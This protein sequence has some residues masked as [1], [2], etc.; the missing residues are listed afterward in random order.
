MGRG[1]LTTRQRLSES[2]EL[3]YCPHSCCAHDHV[4]NKYDNASTVICAACC[5]NQHGCCSVCTTA[6]VCVQV[7]SSRTLRLMMPF[8][9]FISQELLQNEMSMFRSPACLS[10]TPRLDPD[11]SASSGSQNHSHQFA[12]AYKKPPS[13]AKQARAVKGTKRSRSSP[14]KAK[15]SGM[16]GVQQ[17][18]PASARGAAAASKAGM[19]R[20][21]SRTPQLSSTHAS[22]SRR[23]SSGEAWQR[24]TSHHIEALGP[25]PLHFDPAHACEGLVSELKTKL[26]PSP[27]L[28]AR[29]RSM[30]LKL[31]R[32]C[33]ESFSI[34]GWEHDDDGHKAEDVE[35]QRSVE[36]GYSVI[37]NEKDNF[38]A[39]KANLKSLMHRELATKP[40]TSTA[41]TPPRLPVPNFQK[42][43]WPRASTCSTSH[44]SDTCVMGTET[45]PQAATEHSRPPAPE[46][47]QPLKPLQDNAQRSASHGEAAELRSQVRSL[48]SELERLR[49]REEAS[50]ARGHKSGTKSTAAD[51]AVQTSGGARQSD[52]VLRQE[53]DALR[54]ELKLS[55]TRAA[56]HETA[57]AGL[58]DLSTATAALRGIT[59][60]ALRVVNWAPSAKRAASKIAKRVAADRAAPAKALVASHDTGSLVKSGES[61][62]SAAEAEGPARTV[63]QARAAE[64]R[65]RELVVVLLEQ[66]EALRL[67]PGYAE[68]AVARITAGVCHGD[69]RLPA[70]LR[71]ELE[72]L[73]QE[74]EALR[75][76]LE[77]ERMSRRDAV[78]ALADLS[79]GGPGSDAAPV[80]GLLDALHA[81][82]ASAT[83]A[84]RENAE[85]RRNAC[86]YS[87]VGT[88]GSQGARTRT[89]SPAPTWGDDVGRERSGQMEPAELR[90]EAA[91]AAR[92]RAEIVC[93]EREVANLTREVEKGVEARREA[94]RLER[95]VGDLRWEVEK[96]LEGVREVERLRAE[97]AAERERADAA[98]GLEREVRE[99]RAEAGEAAA[100]HRKSQQLEEELEAAEAARD[101]A[102]VAL[103]RQERR[104]LEAEEQLQER[105]K[106]A[107]AAQKAQAAAEE[108]LQEAQSELRQLRQRVATLEAEGGP[109]ALREA[110]LAAEAV[111]RELQTAT[112]QRDKAARAARA[113]EDAAAA[114]AD[115]AADALRRAEEEAAAAQ[116]EAEEEAAARQTL[117]Q[118]VQDAERTAREARDEAARARA[119]TAVAER[120]VRNAAEAAHASSRTPPR[121]GAGAVQAAAME[122]WRADERLSRA[123]EDVER[124]R[125]TAESHTG[126]GGREGVGLDEETREAMARLERRVSALEQERR[127]A[128]ARLEA[129]RVSEH[130]QCGDG[131]E[132]DSAGLLR[133]DEDS[134]TV[135][136]E[137]SRM[138]EGAVWEGGR[139]VEAL[140]AAMEDEVAA[141]SGRKLPQDP[142]TRRWLRHVAVAVQRRMLAAGA[143]ARDARAAT[144]AARARAHALSARLRAAGLQSD[145]VEASSQHRAQGSGAADGKDGGGAE[146]RAEAVAAWAEVARLQAALRDAEERLEVQA[147]ELHRLRVLAGTELAAV[148]RHHAQHGPSG[149]PGTDIST[150]AARQ[151]A[152]AGTQAPATWDPASPGAVGLWSP[153]SV[154]D[155]A[156]AMRGD[157]PGYDESVHVSTSALFEAELSEHGGAAP[158]DGGQAAG[159]AVMGSQDVEPVEEALQRMGRGGQDA[160]LGREAGHCNSAVVADGRADSSDNADRV[161]DTGAGIDLS[162][163]R[164]DD[165]VGSSTHFDTARSLPADADVRADNAAVARSQDGGG[166]AAGDMPDEPLSAA[167]GAIATGM[168][169]PDLLSNTDGGQRDDEHTQLHHGSSNRAGGKSAPLAVLGSP[170]LAPHAPSTHRYNPDD[171]DSPIM[172]AVQDERAAADAHRS[173]A[174]AAAVS[175]GS[176]SGSSGGSS[177]REGAAS[178]P[179]LLSAEGARAGGSAEM[180]SALSGADQASGGRNGGGR[181]SPESDVSLAELARETNERLRQ[182]A[183]ANDCTDDGTVEAQAAG[184]AAAGGAG[185]LPGQGARANAS[186]AEDASPL[187]ADK[188]G[189]DTSAR[190]PHLHADATALSPQQTEATPP[191][192]TSV[193]RTE[194]SLSAD[195]SDSTS[196]SEGTPTAPTQAGVRE[197]SS[198]T[199]G[200]VVLGSSSTPALTPIR[201]GGA[202]T[203]AESATDLDA[204][205]IATAASMREVFRRHDSSIS[206]TA[207]GACGALCAGSAEWA[208]KLEPAGHGSDG[209]TESASDDVSSGS[210]DE[211]EGS[212]G[213]TA[214][215]H[216][217]QPL[218]VRPHSASATMR[219]RTAQPPAVAPATA[220]PALR[221]RRR[222]RRPAAA[223]TPASSGGAISSASSAPDLTPLSAPPAALVY[224][225]PAFVPFPEAPVLTQV[226][227]PVAMG[228]PTRSANGSQR[229]ASVDAGGLA[230]LEALR[231]RLDAWRASP[232]PPLPDTLSPSAATDA[233]T[234]PRGTERPERSAH[235]AMLASGGS[236]VLP[237]LP[238]SRSVSFLDTPQERPPAPHAADRRSSSAGGSGS[239]GDAAE[240]ALLERLR[241]P[242]SAWH[243]AHSHDGRAASGWHKVPQLL[244]KY[245]GPGRLMGHQDVWSDDGEPEEMDAP[246]LRPGAHSPTAG[247]RSGSQAVLQAQE[248]RAARQSG[249]VPPAPGG[250]AGLHTGGSSF[251]VDDDEEDPWLKVQQMSKAVTPVAD[252]AKRLAHIRSRRG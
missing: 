22:E 18:R 99:L 166:N 197:G 31:E 24:S 54:R 58:S 60:E 165:S 48:Q 236:V 190:R 80:Q 112:S 213:N 222:R 164:R 146:Q 95:E 182:I 114:A 214:A 145:A 244:V 152:G 16:A 225:N 233:G 195:G 208:D 215:A 172:H 181:S 220:E 147:A 121:R 59:L 226:S 130:Q 105:Y 19:T 200:G 111:R 231:D 129:V 118:R 157:N 78:R 148:S 193:H 173:A 79:S 109:E 176:E 186:A 162:G 36:E 234:T 49:Q 187:L 21:G 126:H 38:Q 64:S 142:G 138:S 73:T 207:G 132:D 106:E 160:A 216:A 8:E 82:R 150:A 55:R 9:A 37:S 223:R 17:H 14:R 211:S 251:G 143:V 2:V 171:I 252:L 140:V 117:Q 192:Q 23:G 13:G 15:Q 124:L 133:A 232:I 1:K 63:S 202:G 97:L 159:S 156:A 33:G 34:H 11:A 189:G 238:G 141:A 169:Q 29:L 5:H 50:A 46:L 237:S 228:E 61:R 123:F 205:A 90:R 218:Q 84:Q 45:T 56:E 153:E 175:R 51:H 57:T 137:E 243:A 177:A 184:L 40:P 94:E 107:R 104:M 235:S 125:E 210:S 198:A 194:V 139:G 83:A 136:P 12:I 158:H 174:G 67:Q 86:L 116:A 204:E 199:S 120:E 206:R 47:V 242:V 167:A 35:Q 65:A 89:P 122:V 170:M 103:R 100:A 246:P 154:C 30:E 119:A 93:L 101:T 131:D 7:L 178:T 91:S 196:G 6:V 227:A 20:Q 3:P 43:P 221:R 41:S 240:A 70:E 88:P 250:G 110:R 27:D 203:D 134:Q 85:L 25:A 10:P 92:S 68:A 44:L 81:A 102:A 224:G 185:Q 201:R 76:D 32:E 191:A 229:S 74:R 179:Q 180:S 42:A 247:W 219:A 161:H 239:T 217:Q 209:A 151:V 72:R 66:I 108:A 248:S 230:A 62:R 127:D 135:S 188:V 212:R 77:Q 113:A 144:A 26:D 96:G 87:G 149:V 249:G 163:V 183:S 52:A 98:A 155:N 245:G 69:E 4:P 53:N 168:A 28:L 241:G 39:V 71:A 115:E 128:A 75:Q